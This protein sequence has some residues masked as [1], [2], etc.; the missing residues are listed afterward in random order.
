VAKIRKKR[1]GG[2]STQNKKEQV[3]ANNNDVVRS[4]AAA[5]GQSGQAVSSPVSNDNK[6]RES[7]MAVSQGKTSR[8]NIMV[9]LMIGYA[10]V[11]VVLGLWAFNS[12]FYFYF[13]EA[14]PVMGVNTPTSRVANTPK[15]EDKDM[16]D[17]SAAAARIG[18]GIDTVTIH[19]VGPTI[20]FFVTVN[21]GVDLETG[22][23]LGHKAVVAFADA[24]AKPEIFATYEAQIIVTKANLP[25][26]DEKVILRPA[27][28]EGE[29]QSF[30]QYGV[31]NKHTDGANKGISWAHNGT[32]TD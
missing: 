27:G 5:K 1:R 8:K 2:T 24:L 10:I 19:Q 30:P 31:S 20:H 26:L 21:S 18:E 3:N 4:R 14:S 17:A 11:M 9:T 28:D 7:K 16:K 13:T 23:A 22:R 25:T 32:K 15:I 29:E 6:K 12:F